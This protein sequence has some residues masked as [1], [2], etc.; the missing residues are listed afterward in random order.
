[1]GGSLSCYESMPGP[2]R[3]KGRTCF[4]SVEEGDD[5]CAQSRDRAPDDE[6]GLN[7][8]GLSGS[9]WRLSV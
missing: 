1:M 2:Q 6:A 5:E 8:N 4:Q 7:R 9:R 3:R